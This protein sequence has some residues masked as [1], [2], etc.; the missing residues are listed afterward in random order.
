MAGHDQPEPTTD[1]SRREFFRIFGRQ[2]VRQAGA[3]VGA[4]AEIRR[5][6]LAAAQELMDPRPPAQVAEPVPEQAG[7]DWTFRSP[8]RATADAIVAVDQR[9]LPGRVVAVTLREPSEVASAM[10][11]GA[12]NGGPVLGQVAAYAMAIAARAAAERPDASRQQLMRAAA[13]TLRVARPDVRV[14]A[15]AV[16]RV[17]ARYDA[18]MGT[19]A[20]PADVVVALREE[21]DAI[22]SSSIAAMAAI[23]RHAAG[24]VEPQGDGPLSLLM[25]GDMGPMSCGMVG[26]GT[27]LIVALTD[28]GHPLHVWLTEASPSGEGSRIA[29]LQLTQHDVPHTVVP[30][31]AVGWLFDHRH[32]DAAVLRGDRVAV[33]GDVGVLIGGL[34]VARLAGLAGVPLM[35]L[36]PNDARDP[37]AD[38]GS[39]LEW[40][41]RSGA[42][43]ARPAVFGVRLNPTVDVIPARL[44]GRLVTEADD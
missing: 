36:A 28:A 37:G 44:I 34:G 42:E 24:Y 39:A 14:L 6:G 23:G 19:G 18:L 22:A 35:I 11:T 40:E 9:E 32:L 20:A 10:R 41:L 33:N 26:M 38:D 7:P 15:W 31:S 5:S 21:A 17:E 30:D 8:Y 4:A 25:H 16:D 13:N 27:A 29:A 3:V 2:T 43:S 1:A 12:I